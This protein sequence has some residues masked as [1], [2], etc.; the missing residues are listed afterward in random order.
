M[1]TDCQV[2]VFAAASLTDIL[3]VHGKAW[4]T[5]TG[6][7]EPRYSFAASAIMARQIAAGAPADLFISANPDWIEHLKAKSL[8]VD[9]PHAL[10]QN[11]LVYIAPVNTASPPNGLPSAE[12]FLAMLGNKKLAIADPA[13]APAGQYSVRFLKNLGVWD[14]IRHQLAYGTNVRQ[15]LLY[16][17]RGAMTGFVYNSDAR[18]NPRVQIIFNVPPE[19]SGAVIY[20]AALI[21]GSKVGGQSFLDYLASKQAQQD[22]LNAGFSPV[23]SK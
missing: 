8:L 10:I 22:W 13:L 2:T 21:K 16:V 1:A 5:R 18:Q 7:P 14:Q 20:S 19:L 23:A 17:D 9:A 6:C 15:A 11:Q 12:S 4:A 3:P